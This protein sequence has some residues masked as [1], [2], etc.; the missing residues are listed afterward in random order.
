MSSKSWWKSCRPL[1]I[2]TIKQRLKCR[3]SKTTWLNCN[4]WS[5]AVMNS[6][7]V[8]QEKRLDGRHKSLSWMSNTRNSSVTVFL[9]ALLW[10]TAVHSHPS[11]VMN[12][13]PVGSTW[14]RLITFLTPITSTLLISLPIPQFSVNGKWPVCQPTRSPQRMVALLP[15]VFVGL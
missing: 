6:S 14:C 1:K 10:V 8:W 9:P 15:K 4:K 7:I 2:N 13:F 11:T 3:C 12:S 5:I